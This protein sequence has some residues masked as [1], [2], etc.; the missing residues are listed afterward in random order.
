MNRLLVFKFFAICDLITFLKTFK[1]LKSAFS[2]SFS[3]DFLP[4][5][6][7]IVFLLIS[8]LFTAYFN[9]VSIK[10]GI[11]I[12]YFQFIPRLAFVVLTFWFLTYLSNLISFSLY[13]P[14]IYLAMILEL[15]RLI[16]SIKIHRELNRK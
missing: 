4:L 9:I 10:L 11:I 12:Y 16:Y 5:N 14:V 7:L 1:L 13:Q 3:T 8:L 15:F 6:F 2:N